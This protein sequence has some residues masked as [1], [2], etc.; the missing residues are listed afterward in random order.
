MNINRRRLELCKENKL[1]MD[2]VGSILFVLECMYNEN[3]QLLDSF[4]DQNGNRNALIIYKEME[5]VGLLRREKFEDKTVHYSLNYE[6]KIFYEQ[7][8]VFVDDDIAVAAIENR[9]VAD[10]IKD[11]TMLWKDEKGMNLKDKAGKRS[12]GISEKDAFERMN[13]FIGNYGYIFKTTEMTQEEVIMGATKKYIE[14]FRKT[15]FAFC[16]SAYNFIQ[17]QEEGTKE[18]R[19]STLAEWCENFIA[20]S[21]VVVEE[22]DQFSFGRPVL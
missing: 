20:G 3:Y 2:Q 12:L 17:K 18:S 13:V 21:K 9:R 6:G 7:L 10:W 22:A 1:K 8:W 16:K 11:W 15:R 5:K 4:D 19:R 14:E